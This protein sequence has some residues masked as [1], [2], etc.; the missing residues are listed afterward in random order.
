MFFGYLFRSIVPKEN[1]GED[2]PRKFPNIQM[3]MSLNR[4]DF[5]GM[6]ES[7]FIRLL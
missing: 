4:F 1:A 6:K 7:I 2:A 3:K 5:C